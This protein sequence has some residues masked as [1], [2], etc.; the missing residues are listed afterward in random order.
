MDS[1]PIIND[2]IVSSFL[3]IF[4]NRRAMDECRKGFEDQRREKED[5]RRGIEEL[6][7]QN[8]SRKEMRKSLFFNIRC[9]VNRSTATY[10]HC[11]LQRP[12]ITNVEGNLYNFSGVI[13]RFFT[14]FYFFPFS[15]IFILSS[16]I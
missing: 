3:S 8:T 9:S 12:V 15:D 6:K 13:R 7:G 10:S 16:S 2:S 5:I 11:I 14:R 1:Y 4:Q